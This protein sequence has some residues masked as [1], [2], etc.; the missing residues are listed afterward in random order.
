ML[1]TWEDSHWDQG[2][3][4]AMEESLCGSDKKQNQTGRQDNE[5]RISASYRC[6]SQTMQSKNRV[7]V[8]WQQGWQPPKVGASF[9]CF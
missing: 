6:I 1:K 9:S 3:L 8:A 5:I 2:N 7:E 4:E